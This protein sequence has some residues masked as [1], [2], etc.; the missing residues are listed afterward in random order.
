MP[1]DAFDRQPLRR[2][3]FSLVADTRLDNRDDL[4]SALNIDRN[5]I[6][7]MADSALLFECLLAWGESAARRLVGEFAFALWNEVEGTLLLG[8]DLLGHRPLFFHKNDQFFAFASMPSGLHALPDIPKAFDEK[9]MAELL[10]LLPYTDRR[11]YFRGIERVPT[12]QLVRVTPSGVSASSYWSPP[13]AVTG[14]STDEYEDGLR[15]VLDQAVRAQLRGAGDV[16]G[17]HL[18]AG[19]DS[20]IVTSA[21]ARLVAPRKVLAFTAVPRRG[22][23][24]PIPAETIAD[25]SGIAAETARLYP[26]IEHVIIESGAESL[27]DVMDQQVVYEQ[28]PASELAVV[29]TGRAINRVARRRGVNVILV[30]FAGNLTISYSGLEFWSSLFARGGVG[31]ALGIGR[32][33]LQRGLPL[34]TL[35]AQAVGPYLPQS[36]WKLGCR[37]YGRPIGLNEYTALNPAQREFVEARASEM[38]HDFLYRPSKDSVH[39]RVST[40]VEGDNGSYLKGVL[41]EFGVSLRDPTSDLRVIEYC[42]AVPPEEFIR[43]G[44]PRALARNA[45]ADRLPPSVAN[46]I[47]R[48]S[49]A[50]DWFETVERDLPALRGELEA[51]ER[52]APALDPLDATWLRETLDSWPSGGWTR[53]DVLMRYRYG[54]LRGISAGH[55]M[56]KFAGTN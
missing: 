8:R 23:K 56:R 46:F 27:Q 2:G 33:L 29:A 18:S 48:G 11:T 28:E 25:E 17:T 54:L 34:R 12:G 24:G 41:A 16:V 22:F 42:L 35:A 15:N 45:F 47:H 13:A 21:T 44:R 1:E 50:A 20:S 40:L 3:H 55:F 30:G 9:V 52:C 26:N 51:I 6:A 10:A 31:S 39:H 38:G 36:L 7:A 43:D 14:R 49:Q 4:A 19:L 53:R 32:A 37:I 5:A